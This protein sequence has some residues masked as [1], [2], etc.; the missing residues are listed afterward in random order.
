MA[1]LLW[2]G[3]LVGF[4]AQLPQIGIAIWAVNVINATF[5]FLQEYRAEKATQALRRILP[6]YARV[7][8]DHREARIPAQDL[9]PGD[10]VLVAEGDRISADARL[11]EAIELRVDQSTLTGE[12]NPVVK[13]AEPLVAPDTPLVDRAN[14]ILAGTSVSS[15]RGRAV[16]FATGMNTEFGRVASLTE[17]IEEQPS[18]LQHEMAR[19]SRVVSALAVTIGLIFFA[20]AVLIAGVNPSASFIFA[21]GMIV[22]FVP[23]GML[24]TV[25]L[26]LAMGVQRM[27]RRNAL[28]KRLSA[29]E[30]LGSATVICT[31]KTGTITENQMTVQELWMPGRHLTVSGA[32]YARDGAIIEHG[33]PLPT[34]V[35]DDLSELL[36][37]ASLCTSSRVLPEEASSNDE[38]GRR[39]RVEGDSTEGALQIVAAKGGILP[40][41]SPREQRIHEIPFDAKRRRMS[42]VHLLDRVDGAEH[43]ARKTA[44]LYMKG[45]PQ[46]VLSVCSHIRSGGRDQPI[47]NAWQAEVVAANDGFAA[48]GLRVLAA[49]VRHDP[50]PVD[51][52]G[53]VRST[54]EDLEQDLTFLGLLAMR[55]VP[56][57]EVHEAVE[58]C[59]RAG[60]RI[61]MITGDYGL[62][63]KTIARD[64]GIVRGESQVITG[65]DIDAMD[66][67]A[68]RQSL[69]TATIVARA[70]PQH[71]LR[72]V[73]ALQDDGHIV[74]VTGDGVNDAPALKKADIGVAMGRGG[75]DVAREAADM[76]LADD[77]FSS[78][79][80]AIEEGRAVFANIRRFA[81]YVFNSNV[82]E[83]IPFVLMLF[84]RGAIPLPLT[85]MQV[86][87]I[88][89][90]TD[91]VP[92]IG[93]GAERPE[94]NV[95]D[96][97]PRSQ[98]EPLL[99]G[100]ILA[101]ALFWY[102]AIESVAS[103]SGYFFLNWL[104][105]WP[106]V[107]LAPE[108]TEVYRMATTMT[109]A[110][111]VATQVGAVF[112]CRTDHASIFRV[113][114]FTNRLILLGVVTE[115]TLLALIVYVP[116]LQSIF[117]TAPIGLQEW[118]FVFAWTPVIFLADEARKAWLRARSRSRLV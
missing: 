118:L 38:P 95:M 51:Q 61:V 111:V 6:L 68:L 4:I 73:G 106:M 21:M 29:V 13:S 66:D 12:S 75:T 35:D 77:N 100:P 93:L 15:G 39:W 114:F 28:V 45:A 65:A 96:R 19:V 94:E 37:A 115:L 81:V 105:G 55:D 104:N 14:L 113:G 72:V 52:V 2:A 44:V 22:A 42:T 25:T 8:R 82:A 49:A 1:L 98:D 99:T 101:R 74:A 26:S 78:I 108:G 10:V 36:R 46:E 87:A 107:P 69:R 50:I 40:G 7:L 102:G 85:V 16:V 31:D 117:G 58:K 18:P 32:G 79:V 97:P 64:V 70:A 23:E 34:P 62:T 76:V 20:L 84:S 116:A 83:A 80:A 27:A 17:S 11:V 57:P 92:A 33:S 110:G 60:I 56:R 59:H 71:K 24:P 88:D 43:H 41:D 5:S 103:M 54:P 30:T 63:A 48:T 47:D 112:G 53:H 91:M 3:G 67:D 89:L 9:V 90:G 86:L 109:F